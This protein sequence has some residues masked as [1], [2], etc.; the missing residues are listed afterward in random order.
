MAL[1]GVRDQDRLDGASNFVSG[2]AKILFVLNRNRVKHFA[3]R[4]I[5]IP[6]DLAEN[7]KYKEAMARANSIILDGVKDHV[8]PHIAEKDTANA[9]WE[10]LMKLYQY[11]S[12]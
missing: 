12:V 10:A 5:V 9:M 4:T 1:H 3:L 11:T 8:V 6:V 7:D 2:R